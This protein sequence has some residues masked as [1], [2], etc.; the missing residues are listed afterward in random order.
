MIASL[1]LVVVLVSSS[2]SFAGSR[3]D[4]IDGVPFRCVNAMRSEL[5]RNFS[6]ENRDDPEAVKNFKEL[7]HLAATYSCRERRNENV[8]HLSWCDGSAC[9]GA[10]AILKKGHCI[11]SDSWFGQD[12][13][14]SVDEQEDANTCF[15]KSDF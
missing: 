3:P 1:S 9:S 13:S 5:I 6:A 15:R 12:D 14:D 10:T 7:I 4:I 11:V 2:V 8:E